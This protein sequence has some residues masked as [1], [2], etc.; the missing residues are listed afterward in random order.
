MKK[1][2]I[3]LAVLAT[4][5]ATILAVNSSNKVIEQ[6]EA[7]VEALA[8]IEGSVITCSDGTS[9]RCFKSVITVP[10]FWECVWT[11]NPSDYCRQPY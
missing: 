5:V 2:F 8:Q 3:S 7:N 4:C 10:F 6:F 1:I 9:G 11:G